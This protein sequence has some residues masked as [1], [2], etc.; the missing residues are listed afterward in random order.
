MSAG[1]GICNV[2][3]PLGC[4][5]GYSELTASFVVSNTASF[6]E[7]LRQR[8]D[9]NGIYSKNKNVQSD[10][11]SFARQRWIRLECRVISG[12]QTSL[13]RTFNRSVSHR[14]HRS[15]RTGDAQIVF[16]YTQ[17]ITTSQLSYD[18]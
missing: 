7:N 16:F 9:R 8:F 18:I 12:A 10:A 4:E 1:A 6:Y 15:Y 3:E 2:L 14:T 13:S 17:P 5:K 11:E